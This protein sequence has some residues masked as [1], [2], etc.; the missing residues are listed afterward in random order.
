MHAAADRVRV[1]DTIV[2]EMAYIRVTQEGCCWRRSLQEL[3]VE[4]VQKLTEARLIVSPQR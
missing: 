4:D 2:T 1:V 3:T